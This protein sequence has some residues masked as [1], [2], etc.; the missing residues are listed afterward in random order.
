MVSDVECVENCFDK[1]RF[2]EV[3]ESNGLPCISTTKS[4]DELPETPTFVVRERYGAGSRNVRIDI[5]KE[6]ARTDSKDFADPVFSPYIA[7]AEYTVDFYVNRQGELVEAVPRTRDL[8]IGGESWVTTT[9]Y[10]ERIIQLIQEF[11]K[12][13][14]IRGHANLQLIKK[15]DSSLHIIECNPRIGGG[16]GVSIRA[17]C[18]SINWCLQESEGVYVRPQVGSF[19]PKLTRM[20]SKQASYSDSRR[21]K[22]PAVYTFA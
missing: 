20:C 9:C 1:L 11:I 19:Q 22:M 18:N 15:S 2:A 14:M 4:I 3:C 6:E 10:D 5:S 16:S 17:G 12:T 13:F 8:V 21:K 7:G